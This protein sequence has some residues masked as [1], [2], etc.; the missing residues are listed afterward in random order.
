[1]KNSYKNKSL[2]NRIID[3]LER[4]NRG[5]IKLILFNYFYYFLSKFKKNLN[6]KRAYI[7]YQINKKSIFAEVGV[8]KGDFS[9]KINKISNPKKLILVDPWIFDE[10]IRGCAPQVNGQEPLNQK[11]F[12]NA[13]SET[14]KKFINCKNIQIIDNYSYEASMLFP[15][16]YFDYIYIDGEHT[17]T[18]VTNDLNYWYPKLK[19]NGSIYGDDYYWREADNSLSLHRAYQDFIY[20]NKIKNWCVFKSQICLI[21]NHD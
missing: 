5:S 2:S 21:K 3:K 1:M 11:Y 17:Y 8:W 12:D 10:K 9:E 19:K 15:D 6:D 7:L 20:K 13:K 18:A 4:R 14:I 16:E